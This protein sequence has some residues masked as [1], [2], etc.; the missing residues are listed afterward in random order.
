M[1]AREPLAMTCWPASSAFFKFDG[2]PVTKAVRFP[3]NQES[4]SA[5]RGR[6]LRFVDTDV[7]FGLGAPAGRVIV[8][9]ANTNRASR[10]RRSRAVD[11]RVLPGA[12]RSDYE[13]KTPAAGHVAYSASSRPI[14][15]AGAACMIL[16]VEM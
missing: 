4:L 8:R 14:S 16:L 1:T 3:G 5:H 13:K 2:Q 7:G 11:Q 10:E 9:V 15:T 6:E 12:A